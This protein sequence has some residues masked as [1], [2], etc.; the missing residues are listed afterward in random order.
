MESEANNT[1]ELVYKTEIR[2]TYIETKLTVAKG[3]RWRQ[4]IN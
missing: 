2:P 3:N 1:S 4:R